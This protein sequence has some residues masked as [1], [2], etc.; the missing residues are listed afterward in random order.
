MR[1]RAKWLTGI[2]PVIATTVMLGEEL[3]VPHNLPDCGVSIE[4][5]GS[6]F[7]RAAGRSVI[8]ESNDPETIYVPSPW[9]QGARVEKYEVGE[10]TEINPP[11]NQSKMFEIPPS[12]Y[13]IDK[14]GRFP[15]LWDD[16]W[17]TD[18][19]GRRTISPGRY[20]FVLHFLT[21]L[22]SQSKT[23]VVWWCRTKSESFSLKNEAVVISMD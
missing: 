19:D 21:R 15:I 7:R 11:K 10:W 13:E 20:R 4:V 6:H 22:P 8:L 18:T 17:V 9:P 16:V 2:L 23:H 3:A 1:K 12:S 5:L 14:H